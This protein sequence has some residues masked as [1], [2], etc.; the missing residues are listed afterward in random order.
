[1]SEKNDHDRAKIEVIINKQTFNYGH[2]TFQKIFWI[3]HKK[4]YNIMS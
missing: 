1:M 2:E 4:K 3:Q